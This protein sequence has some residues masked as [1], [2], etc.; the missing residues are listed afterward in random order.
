MG[1]SG[2]VILCDL[3]TEAIDHNDAIQP[4]KM[5]NTL[6]QQRMCI[7]QTITQYKFVYRVLIAYL[8]RARLI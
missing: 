3:L 4:S 1:R 5:L 8:S 2:I 7:V 6:R